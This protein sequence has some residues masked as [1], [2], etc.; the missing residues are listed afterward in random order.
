MTK[1]LRC[2]DVG[3]QC[4]WVARGATEQ[5]VL[6]KAGEHAAA[7]HNMKNIPPETL[8]KIRAAVRDE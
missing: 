4:D 3:M 5:E 2:R 6:K 8:A 7:T 1:V